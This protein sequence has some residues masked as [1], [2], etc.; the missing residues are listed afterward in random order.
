MIPFQ[1]PLA[2]TLPRHPAFFPPLLTMGT[3]FF[4]NSGGARNRSLRMELALE[5]LLLALFRETP[6][7]AP[8]LEISFRRAPLGVRVIITDSEQRHLDPLM[9][10]NEELPPTPDF[11]EEKLGIFLMKKMADLVSLHQRGEAGNAYHLFFSLEEPPV[12]KELSKTKGSP[13]GDYRVLQVGSL[14]SGEAGKI[15]AFL[16]EFCP[17]SFRQVP[18]LS[19]EKIRNL[20]L[21]EK[22]VPSTLRNKEEEIFGFS[23][24]LYQEENPQAPHMLCPW[25]H[26]ELPFAETGGQMLSYLLD[27]A[28]SRGCSA[29]NSLLPSGETSQI[30]LFLKHGFFQC[31]RIPD[32]FDF[33]RHAP[34]KTGD[35]LCRISRKESLP[36]LFADWEDQRRIEPLLRS[37]GLFPAFTIPQLDTPLFGRSVLH[38]TA[39]GEELRGEIRILHF[40]VDVFLQIRQALKHLRKLGIPGVLL[41]LPLEKPQTAAFAEKIHEMGFNTCGVMPNLP[42]SME[43][44]LYLPFKP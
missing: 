36:P 13:P 19:P 25:I 15:T 7:A 44:L 32:C 33:T 37:A 11:L 23:G 3:S 29:V 34:G 20:L 40:G 16:Q 10:Q 41:K 17:D 43:M 28:D 4:I 22:L 31:A 1:E 39:S 2:V 38:I 30:D 9:L 42:G 24:L 8:P 26:P 14:R 6:H 12:P 5:E 35:L 27:Q 21:S 18:W